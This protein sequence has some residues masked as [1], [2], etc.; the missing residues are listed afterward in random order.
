VTRLTED[1]V[2]GLIERLTAFEEGLREVAGMGLRE[3]A[4]ATVADP[5]VCVPLHGAR[6]AAVPITS[7]Q[8]VIS[9]FT[10]C[11]ATILNH[12][13]CDAWVTNQPDVRGL[14]EAITS[15]AEVVFLADDYRFIALDVRKGRCIDDD[16]ATAD[17]YVTALAAAAGGL[18]G[19]PVLLLGLG[20]VGRAAARRLVRLGAKVE[21]VEPDQAR[22][23]AA[24]DIGLRIRPTTLEDGLSRCRLILDAT[25][26]PGIIDAADISAETIV[27]VPGI[28]SAF[29]AAAQELLGVRHIHEPLAVG[30]AVMAARA[31]V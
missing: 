14:Q 4:M 27:A 2:R 12:L 15:R 24:L 3:L 10:D 28:P 1:D 13:G 8:G 20:P 21:V 26:A 9:G 6:I 19:R 30:V 29:T 25:P 11:V 23:Q 16:P 22:L 5:P 17:G 18:F 7:G 31:L